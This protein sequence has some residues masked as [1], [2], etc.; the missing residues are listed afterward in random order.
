MESP[1]TQNVLIVGVGGQGVLL[2]SD[3]LGTVCLGRGYQVKKSEVHGMAKRGGV[4]YSHVRY[5]TQVL[6]P[7]IEPGTSDVL[8]AF[9]PAEALRWSKY[10]K[11]TGTVI[12]NTQ[13]RIPPAACQDRRP[14]ALTRYPRGIEQALRS[15]IEDVRRFDA[16]TLAFELGDLR[17]CNTVLLGALSRVCEFSAEEWL[18]AIEKSVKPRTA[19]LNRRAFLAGR[20]VEFPCAEEPQAEELV[21]EKREAARDEAPFI[22][23]RQNWCKGCEI[24]V[25]VCP[26]NCL[27]MNGSKLAE[28]AKAETCIRCMLC[29]WLCPDLAVSVH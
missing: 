18:A 26:Q 14:D 21:F 1:A 9:E 4:V 28:V 29:E 13:K 24:C 10:V 22:E 7:T 2:A 17:M 20:S 8:L 5:G 23:I 12:V 15:Q 11:P 25:R 6:S 27:V 16:E 3:I 19:E